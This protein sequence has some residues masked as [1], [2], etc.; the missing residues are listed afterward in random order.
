MDKESELVIRGYLSKHSQLCPCVSECPL[1]TALKSNNSLLDKINKNQYVYKSLPLLVLHIEKLYEYYLETYF[2]LY[3][4]YAVAESGPRISFARFIINFSSEPILAIKYLRSAKDFVQSVQDKFFIYRYEKLL[5]EALRNRAAL[6]ESSF[7]S[8]LN[9]LRY[10]KHQRQF[11]RY[12]D[13]DA[14]LYMQ[15][16]SG[17]I[18]DSPNMQKTCEIG[19]RIVSVDNNIIK[20]WE[21]MQEIY[22]NNHKDLLSYCFFV[23]QIWNDE[24]YSEEIAEKA[25][26]T[27]YLSK[28]TTLLMA[29]MDDITNFS[30]DGSSCAFISGDKVMYSRI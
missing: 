23:K 11:N 2:L 22:H 15:L 25:R 8:V 19:H 1:A 26:D 3:F 10:E 28:H 7:I 16:W 14:A 6:N 13:E 30:I 4:S 27:A 29:N 17:L 18:D 5:Q 12:L 24:E 21:S 20:H 9:I